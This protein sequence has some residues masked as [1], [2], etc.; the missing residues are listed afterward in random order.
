MIATLAALQLLAAA[1]GTVSPPPRDP[2]AAA[3]VQL[4]QA[5]AA[6]DAESVPPPAPPPEPEPG[7][8]EPAPA[9]AKEPRASRQA[10]AVVPERPRQLS[11]LSAE[12]LGGGSAA[13]AWAGW[14][15][16]GG[17]YAIGFSPRDDGGL[18]LDHDWAKSETRIGI[19]YRRPLSPAGGFGV[20]ARLAVAW[21]ET[22]GSK[23]IEAT[24]HS[25]R[26][27]EVMPGVSLSR[28]G[29]GGVFSALVEGPL[30]ITTKYKNGLLFTPRVS[31]A[32]E[33]PLYPQVTVGARAGVGYRAGAGGAPVKEGQAE[34]QFLVL[35]GYQLL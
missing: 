17:A 16:I 33:A 1:P 9:P 32:F 26:G 31:F 28:P 5:P 20:A 34:L 14:T 27:F 30:T 13:L 15:S 18:Y 2:A 11:L 8:P 25:D 6:P 19:L 10:G 12:S 22:F 3:P 29:A 4:A 7:A 35:A 24:N 23:W 21:Y